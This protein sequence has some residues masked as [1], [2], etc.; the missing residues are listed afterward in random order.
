MKWCEF[1]SKKTEEITK[2]EDPRLCASRLT[3]ALGNNTFTPNSDGLIALHFDKHS[4]SAARSAYSLLTSL[5]FC[6]RMC[7]V[8]LIGTLTAARL[9]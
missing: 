6:V 1:A 8:R 9:A 4:T 5:C 2:L 7:R 3:N